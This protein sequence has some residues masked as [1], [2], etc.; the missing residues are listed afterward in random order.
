MPQPKDPQWKVTAK[1]R[2]PKGAIPAQII[3]K[4]VDHTIGEMTD[5]IRKCRKDMEQQL[6]ELHTLLEDLHPALLQSAK[7]KA[8]M[9][10]LRLS[11]PS[12]DMAITNFL[13]KLSDV[14]VEASKDLAF[15]I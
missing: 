7:V 5:I 10:D 11:L 1:R 13:L 9:N 3:S 2:F 15:K 4:A 6:F 12:S 14:A 8:A